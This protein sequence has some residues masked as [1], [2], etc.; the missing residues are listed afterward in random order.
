MQGV[1]GYNN[2]LNGVHETEHV[3]GEVDEYEEFSE[4]NL[5]S[6]NSLGDYE[7]VERAADVLENTAKNIKVENN[8]VYCKSVNK[9]DQNNEPVW[10]V[11]PYLYYG[12]IITNPYVHSD[13]SLYANIVFFLKGP[14]YAE[15]TP[16]TI[17]F[18]ETLIGI[19][20]Y[21]ESLEYDNTDVLVTPNAESLFSEIHSGDTL[22]IKNRDYYKPI[23]FRATRKNGA[24]ETVNGNTGVA[25]FTTYIDFYNG[26]NDR[27]RVAV[28]FCEVVLFYRD[29][30]GYNGFDPDNVHMTSNHGSVSVTNYNSS[31]PNYLQFKMNNQNNQ[32]YFWIYK[33]GGLEPNNPEVFIDYSKGVRF[34]IRV[35]RCG[36]AGD[37]GFWMTSIGQKPL[38]WSDGTARFDKWTTY[39]PGY[40]PNYF[41]EFFENGPIYSGPDIESEQMYSRKLVLSDVTTSLKRWP[42]L[43]GGLIKVVYPYGGRPESYSRSLEKDLAI[44]GIFRSGGGFAGIRIAEIGIMKFSNFEIDGWEL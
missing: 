29:G 39:F 15:E 28:R 36:H 16:V 7:I 30:I 4:S 42:S 33:R 21:P 35:L 37:N 9:V 25:P 2:L 3:Y 26:T 13:T 27:K 43:D 22:V 8:K 6:V 1:G 40:V 44:G 12:E 20:Q 41:P 17:E 19:M 14:F 10:N 11:T 34:Y 31:E 18:D 5:Y 32:G 23:K 38:D 24:V